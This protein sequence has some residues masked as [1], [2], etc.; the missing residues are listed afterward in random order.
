[1][2]ADHVQDLPGQGPVS[3]VGLETSVEQCGHKTAGLFLGD[4]VKRTG[5]VEQVKQQAAQP[6]DVN[7]THVD[8][9][10]YIWRAEIRVSQLQTVHFHVYLSGVVYS[11]RPLEAT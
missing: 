8:H 7:F 5:P 11:E 9:V 10:F 4:L 2:G 6:P 3:G 1:M